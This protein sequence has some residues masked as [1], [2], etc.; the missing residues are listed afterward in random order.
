MGHTGTAYCQR[1]RIIN[2]VIYMRMWWTDSIRG[3]LKKQVAWSVS[4]V[5]MSR[6]PLKVRVQI[7][8]QKF[9]KELM[10]SVSYI[11]N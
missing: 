1:L 11:F 2:G 7:E 5:A 8:M 10:R 9:K 6:V 3:T 4:E